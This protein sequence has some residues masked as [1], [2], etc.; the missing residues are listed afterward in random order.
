VISDEDTS[1]TTE[2]CRGKN[3]NVNIY[4]DWGR[5]FDFR[6]LIDLERD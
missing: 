6:M 3:N 1:R 4:L 5:K 2:K